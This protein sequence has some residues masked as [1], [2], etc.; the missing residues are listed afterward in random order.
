MEAPAITI[1]K[2][3]LTDW[4]MPDKPIPYEIEMG[5]TTEKETTNEQVNNDKP[6]CGNEAVQ[7]AQSQVE[8][9]A[10]Q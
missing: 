3:L 7:E 2:E 10:G 6:G 5:L 8:G 4:E 1:P 9:Q